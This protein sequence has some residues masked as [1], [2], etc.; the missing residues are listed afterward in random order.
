MPF[1]EV[2]LRLLVAAVLSGLIGFERERRGRAAGLR[3]HILVGVGSTLIML[4]GMHLFEVYRGQVALDPTRLGAQVVSGIGFLGAGAIFR[5]KASV[6]GLTTAA[7]LWTVA[8][9]G[10]A[11]GS[12]FYTGAILTTGIAL[13]VLLVLTKL[14]PRHM[15]GD[16][17]EAADV[18]DDAGG[19]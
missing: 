1:S 19:E 18:N 14:E 12:G 7:S 15:H 9:V 8:G 2:W 3:T 4:T 5:S 13:I 11:V 6:R 10:L 16:G 17:K